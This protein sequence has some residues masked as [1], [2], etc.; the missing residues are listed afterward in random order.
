[1]SETVNSSMTDPPATLSFIVIS[2][3]EERNIERCIRSILKVFEGRKEHLREVILV[4]SYSTDRT[5]EIARKYPINILFP[6]T[7]K[8]AILRIN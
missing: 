3:N 7:D 2:K 4:D 8:R 6:I 1:M 5:V